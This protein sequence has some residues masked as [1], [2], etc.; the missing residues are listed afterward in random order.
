MKNGL[1]LLGID[2]GKNSFHLIGHDAG[3]HQVLRK[4]FN[5]N[6]LLQFAAQIEPC[7]IA[8]ESCGGSHW[9]ARKLASLGHRVK[10]IAP[11][12]VKPYVTG[13]KNDFI[14]AEAICEAASRPSTHYVAVKTVEQQVLSVQHRLRQSLVCHRTEAINRVHGFLLEFGIA[15]PATKAAIAKVPELIDDSR[16]DL[17]LQFKRVMEHLL[18]DIHRLDTEIKA[19]DAQIKQQLAQDDAGTRLMTIPGIGPITASAFVADLGDASNFRASRD[20]S[21]FLGL[22]PRQFSTGGRPVLLGISKRGDRHLRT[23]L[24]QGSRALMIRIE[25]RDD[26]LG[27]WV[28][29]LLARKHPNKV[30]CAL[31][32]KLARIVWAVLRRGSTYN[33]SMI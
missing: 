3:G 33:A 18:E 31:A 4:C 22:V 13:N 24:V 8:M 15:L 23:L 28:R 1:K 27:Q 10:L 7:T 14:D 12:H 16:S 32:N 20:L 11:Q 19:C 5:R 21:A 6:R 29:D 30:A 25:R 9:L 2:I 26:A 17:P